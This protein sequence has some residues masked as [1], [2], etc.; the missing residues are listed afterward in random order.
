MSDD[1]PTEDQRAS[2]WREIRHYAYV[3]RPFDDVWALLARA[4]E[5]VLG[6]ETDEAGPPEAS[7]HATRAGLELSRDVRLHFGGLVCGEQRARLSLRWE[8][9]HHPRLFPVLEAVLELAPLRSG[10]RQIT[11]IGV[12]GR[13]RPPLG[14]VGALADRL[15]GEAVAAESVA[16]FVK[17]LALKLE[18]LIAEPA[19]DDVD[20]RRPPAPGMRRVY[21]PVDR[22]DDRPGGAACVGRYL[23]SAPGVVQAEVHPLTGL[24]TVDFDPELCNPLKLMEELEDDR[25]WFRDGLEAVGPAPAQGSDV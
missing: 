6:G 14:A 2:G 19:A 11:Q 3:E 16:R 21:I 13:Y 8:D 15:G 7:L 9:V 23:E 25:E 4:P 22:L 18:G 1:V 10:R 17:E 5:Q 24:A 12:V 20:V